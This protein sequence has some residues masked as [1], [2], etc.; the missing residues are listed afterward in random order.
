MKIQP[1]SIKVNC[2]F[3][4][5]KIECPENM[6]NAKKHACFECF[7]N[8]DKKL[9]NEEIENIHVDIPIDKKDEI[10]D[11]FVNSI[12]EEVFPKLWKEKKSELKEMSKRELA[13]MMFAAGASITLKN[14]Q[15]EEEK[16]EEEKNKKEEEK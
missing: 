9:S 15:M 6:I 1:K 7:K 2:S 4:G 14:M 5:K 8:L 13:E 3:C 12:L 10:G 11:M 16:I